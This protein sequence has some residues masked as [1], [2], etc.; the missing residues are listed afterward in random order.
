MRQDQKCIPACQRDSQT[1]KARDFFFN[2]QMQCS[3][4]NASQEAE[5]SSHA[6]LRPLK[7]G[8]LFAENGQEDI[9]ICLNLLRPGVCHTSGPGKH[10]SDALCMSALHSRAIHWS[11]IPTLTD[12][13]EGKSQYYDCTENKVR[14]LRQIM[15]VPE[16]LGC[17][18][19]SVPT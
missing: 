5:M 7:V 2:C 19:C 10:A 3:F 13:A 8:V 16:Y 18:S 1:P 9:L 17:S 12:K 15:C 14:T 6:C 4:Q 11:N